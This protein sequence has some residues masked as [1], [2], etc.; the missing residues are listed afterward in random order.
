MQM[1]R[2]LL[3][4]L[5]IGCDAAA[6]PA[7]GAGGRSSLLA[8]RGG[9]LAPS[10]PLLEEEADLEAVLDEAGDALVIVDFYAEWCGPCRKLAPVLESLMKKTNSKKVQF[11]KV[12]VDKARELAAACGI[13]S[14]PTMQFFKHGEKVNQIVGGDT[15]AL[16]QEVAKATLPA[17]VRTL[18][19]DA[20][21]AA[22]V[23][24]PKQS[25]MLIAAVVYVFAPWQRL[26]AA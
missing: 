5:A 17:L 4:L 23:T 7:L 11:Y 21:T 12:D 26:L 14:M 22:L 15:G 2:S 25:A 6:R 18:H 9:E 8:L 20:I 3:L 10:V 24:S 16:K 13:K 1:G 19:I